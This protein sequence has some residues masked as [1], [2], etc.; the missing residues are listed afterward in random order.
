MVWRYLQQ[1]VF[2][3]V[4]HGLFQ[5]KDARGNQFDGVI[6]ARGAVIG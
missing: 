3:D 2:T 6:F 1:F 5:T 4:F